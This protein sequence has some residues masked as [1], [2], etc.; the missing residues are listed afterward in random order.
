MNFCP[1]CGQ[2]VAANT[3]FCPNC[4]YDLQ[5]KAAHQ[6]QSAKQSQ[7]KTASPLNTAQ[8]QETVK[9]ARTKTTTWYRSASQQTKWILGAVVVV[10][11]LAIGMHMYHSTVS[12][13]LIRHD[14]WYFIMGSPNDQ[15]A[16]AEADNNS[17]A[18]KLSFHKNNKVIDT[19]ADGSGNSEDST[20][21]LKGKEFTIKDSNN[22][23]MKG[24]LVAVKGST[25]AENY[26][27]YKLTNIKMT[28]VDS[29]DLTGLNV[30]IV[31]EK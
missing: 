30:Y 22:E 3:K 12:Q 27:G 10:V 15:L 29:S 7:S 24:K 31:R 17:D 9:T 21:T 1:N 23:T 8:L 25:G 16:S 4:G 18:S 13:Q 19:D 28:G 26:T 20:W 5:A 14:P 2:K 11:V 6:Q